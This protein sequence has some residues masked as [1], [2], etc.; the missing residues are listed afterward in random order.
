MQLNRL[1]IHYSKDSV[2]FAPFIL[3]DFSM[4]Q[5]KGLMICEI[6]TMHNITSSALDL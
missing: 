4:I 5:V 2:N 6:Q 1:K 3:K